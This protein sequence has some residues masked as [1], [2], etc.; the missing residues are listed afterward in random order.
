M[1][2]SVGSAAPVALPSLSGNETA[3]VV[4][5]QG[6]QRTINS[7][8]QNDPVTKVQAGDQYFS[9]GNV[10][11]VQAD[12]TAIKIFDSVA[13]ARLSR[14][15][16]FTRLEAFCNMGN[17]KAAEAYQALKNCFR[18][19]DVQSMQEAV[20]ELLADSKI[21]TD[22][23]QADQIGT[24]SGAYLPSANTISSDGPRS[25]RGSKDPARVTSSLKIGSKAE[26]TSIPDAQDRQSP[27]KIG[28]N[29][30]TTV[31]SDGSDNGL[32]SGGA[33]GS[34]V[35]N[36]DHKYTPMQIASA[37]KRLNPD[38]YLGS[39][40]KTPDERIAALKSMLADTGLPQDMQNAFL[41]IAFNEAT[42]KLGVLYH[43]PK[44]KGD[45]SKGY[46][47][48]GAYS[49]YVGPGASITDHDRSIAMDPENHWLASAAVGFNQFISGSLKNANGDAYNS[50]YGPLT[51]M[52]GSHQNAD[53]NNPA[54]GSAVAMINMLED[55]LNV[56]KQ[57]R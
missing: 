47:G 5:S 10:Y 18:V 52:V 53:V 35:Y 38:A 3:L 1:I 2:T 43:D 16:F 44:D 13:D 40:P 56:A 41:A 25:D 51:L 6:D 19:K 33:P 21:R 4:T 45:L 55:N 49:A 30:D 48:Y 22:R 17:K 32:L 15:D 24:E 8:T 50:R 54:G 37:V 39:N 23:M 11:Q 29:R 27:S 46:N 26:N 14:D 9:Q 20:P 36:L 57:Y 31:I 28:T 7:T 34:M 42:T 12:G